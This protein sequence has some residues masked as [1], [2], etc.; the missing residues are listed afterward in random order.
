[1]RVSVLPPG[2]T[3]ES[4]SFEGSCT[5]HRVQCDA[6]SDRLAHH[7][8][9]RMVDRRMSSLRDMAS[10]VWFRRVALLGAGGKVSQAQHWK[11]GRTT[12]S[13]LTL[14]RVARQRPS[15]LGFQVAQQQAQLQSQ[16]H[17]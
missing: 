13:K 4:A 3:D 2:L 5:V 10:L 11:G 9:R 14:E 1:M 15:Q 17:G 8:S 6:T 7:S 16:Q 12:F